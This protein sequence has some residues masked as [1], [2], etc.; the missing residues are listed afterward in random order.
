MGLNRTKIEW[1]DYTRNP[2]KGKCKMECKDL[3][4]KIYCYAIKQYNRFKWNPEVRFVPTALNDIKSLKKPSKIFLCS[5]HEIFGWWIHKNWILL[6]LDFIEQ[7]PQHTFIILTKKPERAKLFSFPKNV[8]LG[9]TV[10]RRE[11]CWRIDML[12]RCDAK[13]KFVS[14][15]PLYEEI[16]FKSDDKIS[17]FSDFF[18]YG[19]DWIIIGS[20]T[21]PLKIP[22]KDWVEKLIEQAR[23]HG[24]AVFLK[25]NL[26]WKETVREFPNIYNSKCN[27]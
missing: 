3:K 10:T 14:F 13:V 9:V 20:Q 23:K 16:D 2:F 15:E 7:F 1:A 18:L 21:Q 5:T 17:D 26:H 4:G 25:D 8:W 6:I 12:K 19:I 24:I 11:E 22:D 27:T